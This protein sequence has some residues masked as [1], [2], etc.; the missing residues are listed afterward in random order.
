MENVKYIMRLDEHRKLAGRSGV[1]SIVTKPFTIEYEHEGSR[2][3][4]TVPADFE[5]D[6]N[7]TPVGFKNLMERKGPW[8]E[9]AIVHDCIYRYHSLPQDLGDLLYLAGLVSANV[10]WF[11]RKGAYGSLYLFGRFAYANHDVFARAH[12]GE[13]VPILLGKAGG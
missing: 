3:S 5:H 1:H 9:I 11:R 8:Y 10:A 13:V 7:S 6:G 12:V 4:Y 2:Y